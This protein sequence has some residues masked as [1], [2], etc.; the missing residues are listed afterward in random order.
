MRRGWVVLIVL[1][2]IVSISGCSGNDLAAKEYLLRALEYNQS[3]NDFQ[4]TGEVDATNLR[5]TTWELDNASIAF[6]G[7]AATNPFYLESEN[8]LITA[9]E[10]NNLYVD[11]TALGIDDSLYVN[12]PKVLRAMRPELDREYLRF[13][14]KEESAE[15][16]D[17]SWSVKAGKLLAPLPADNFSYGKANLFSGLF[18]GASKIV[19]VTAKSLAGVGPF[20]QLS[21]VDVT[22][23]FDRNDYVRQIVFSGKNIETEISGEIEISKINEGISSKR[24]PPTAERTRDYDEIVFPPSIN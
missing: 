19:R 11:I 13:T 1:I 21:D 17:E 4:F 18:S 8:R 5:G 22:F 15:Q 3:V 12:V 24:T 23:V 16:T 10:E 9:I 2:L 20:E 6:K 14:G 7:K